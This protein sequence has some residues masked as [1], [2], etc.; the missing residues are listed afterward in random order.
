MCIIGNL[1][2]GRGAATRDK[3]RTEQEHAWQQ[4]WHWWWNVMKQ[5]KK[6]D[7]EWRWVAK[8]LGACSRLKQLKYSV[9]I[10]TVPEPGLSELKYIKM[11]L[12]TIRFL[13]PENYVLGYNA[14]FFTSFKALFSSL[15]WLCLPS[16]SGQNMCFLHKIYFLLKYFN[17]ISILMICIHEHT[18]ELDYF[19]VTISCFLM[20]P[21]WVENKQ[22]NTSGRSWEIYI[23]LIYFGHVNRPANTLDL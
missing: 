3:N 10:I 12:K 14:I 5:H 2:V 4:I 6:E 15:A 13:F 20:R 7:L 11:E 9:F 21:S 23:F 19:F 8:Q 1:D 18:H 16:I 17:Y 22:H